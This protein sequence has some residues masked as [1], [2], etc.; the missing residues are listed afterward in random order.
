MKICF[1]LPQM[2]IKPIGGYK[3]VYE[4]ANRLS[5][6][7][8]D[9]G[10][11]FLNKNALKRFHF[12]NFIRNRMLYI[13]TTIEPR[14]FK[15]NS[16]IHKWSSTDRK[17][18]EKLLN[19]D[20]AI[21]TGVDTVQATI[22]YFPYSHKTYFIQG[23]ERWVYSEERINSTFSMD[24]DKIVISGWLKNIVDKYSP[25]P[26]L[27]IKNPIDTNI[28]KYIVPIYLRDDYTLGVLYHNSEEKGFKYA[29]DAILR[30]KEKFPNLKVK[31][32]GTS[33]PKMILPKWIDFKL[34][35]SQADT[36][37]IYNNVSIFLCATINEGY[38]LTGL[39]AMACGAALVSTEYQGVKEYAENNYNALLSPVFDVN[40]LV[41]NASELFVNKQKRY[42]IAK[43][44]IDSAQNFSYTN[45]LA[46]FNNY[47]ERVSNECSI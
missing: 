45:A 28:Y 41:K 16:M 22:D 1:V 21:A 3:I 27:L 23:Y 35:A 13:F 29:Y 42:T 34:N 25:K 14:W 19:T 17:I 5:E 24:L 30:L 18:K 33:K 2:L 46:K 31:M 39:E 38:G 32:F 26:S 8:H 12:P 43:N 36:V 40:I 10:I 7:G 11:L 20:L 47:L 6:E 4:Y 37:D 15:L 44:G 9:I